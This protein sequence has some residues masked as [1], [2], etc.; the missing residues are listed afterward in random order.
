MVHE[1][2]DTDKHRQLD[3]QVGINRHAEYQIVDAC[4]LMQAILV[5]EHN[6]CTAS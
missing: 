3:R 4:R 5:V 6:G 2:S 1:G